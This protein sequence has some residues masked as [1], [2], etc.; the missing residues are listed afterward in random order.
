M[1]LL[2][3]FLGLALAVSVLVG[4]RA[5]AQTATTFT[6][7]GRLIESN[8][9][10]TG[11]YDF[12]F[13]IHD[14][15]DN[16]DIVVGPLLASGVAV[17]NGL[18]AVSLDFD[19]KVFTGEARW[20]EIRVRTNDNPSPFVTLSP[21]QPLTATPYAI[22]A[23]TASNLVGTISASQVTNLDVRG[24]FLTG[25]INQ[26]PGSFYT[27]FGGASGFALATA[28]ESDVTTLSPNE[29]GT[30][31]NLSVQLTAAPGIGN[32]VDVILRVNAFDTVLF[33]TVS[34]E[35]TTANSGSNVA[36]VPPGSQLTIK[37]RSINGGGYLPP[38]SVLFGWTFKRSN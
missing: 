20:L 38:T 18:F 30:A 4:G 1:K 5:L 22:R 8:A 28:T 34:G 9:P 19:P 14:K 16:A 37:V 27:L 32:S 21:R 11:S 13:T 3:S 15:L 25:R 24:G 31:Q 33:C 7:Q 6:Y 17:S 35:S 23:V 26:L 10:A 12:R 36:T 2:A 29:G